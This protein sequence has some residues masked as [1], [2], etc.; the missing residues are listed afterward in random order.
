MLSSVTAAKLAR[1]EERAAELERRAFALLDAAEKKGDIA[2]SATM[3][4]AAGALL[5]EQHEIIM[6]AQSLPPA[7]APKVARDLSRL[8]KEEL[9]TY[10]EL[11]LKTMSASSPAEDDAPVQ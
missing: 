8:T 10:R 7:P 1:I 2:A 4:R 9:R 3:I 6:S 11:L 5:R